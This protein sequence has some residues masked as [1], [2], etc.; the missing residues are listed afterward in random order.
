MNEYYPFGVSFSGGGLSSVAYSGFIDVLKENGLSPSL[1]AGL[2]G[3]ALVS[4]LLASNMKGAEIIEFIDKFKT[5]KIINTNLHNIEIFDHNKL[6]D[7]IRSLLPYK[8]FEDLPIKTLIFSSDLVKKS[9]LVLDSGDLASAIVSSCSAFPILSPVKRLGFILGDGGF[10]TYFGAQMIREAGVKKVV[11]IDVV[12]ILE[13]SVRGLFGSLYKGINSSLYSIAR[14]ELQESPVDVNIQ[15]V[16]PSPNIFS[17]DKKATHII[18][19]GRQS[20]EKNIY[21]IKKALRRN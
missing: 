17:F 8:N 15:I 9:P 3:G 1:Y 18:N 4:V 14:Y 21:K 7:L 19:L 6:T 16:F 12:G 5:L 13:G 2:S 11:G 10:T 20:A